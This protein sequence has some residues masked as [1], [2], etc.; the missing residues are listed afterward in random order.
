MVFFR[1][2]ICNIL[3]FSTLAIMSV[4]SVFLL[5]FPKQIMIKYW[6][7]LAYILSV[8]SEYIAGIKVNLTGVENTKKNCIFASRH[9]SLWETMY[10]ITVID[11]PI[12]VLKKELINIPFFGAMLKKVG[13]ISIDRSQGGAALIKMAKQVNSAIKEGRSVIIFPEG[14]RKSPGSKVEIKKG[15]AMLYRTTKCGVV[16]VALNSGKFW[17][18]YGFIRH[19]GTVQVKFLD[20]IEPGLS[21]EEFTKLLDTRLNSAMD[22]INKIA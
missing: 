16:P 15:I 2:L 21:I 17:P 12:F 4:F 6:H 10:L 8:I 18:K 13:S 5:P 1:S 22:E 19:P 9:E 7:L 3:F 14:T 11:D 20:V